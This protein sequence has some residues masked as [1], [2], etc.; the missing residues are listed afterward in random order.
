MRRASPEGR[1]AGTA[2]WRE[3]R[4]WPTGAVPEAGTV[5]PAA[6]SPPPTLS[7]WT[8]VPTHGSLRTA[9]TPAAHPG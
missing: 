6:R 5:K 3:G 4:A 7:P 1:G 8:P 9:A 2:L